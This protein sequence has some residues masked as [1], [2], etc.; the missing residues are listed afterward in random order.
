M[1][2]DIFTCYLALGFA[3]LKS[4]IIGIIFVLALKSKKKTRNLS[5]INVKLDSI[6]LIINLSL[7]I[8]SLILFMIIDYSTQALIILIL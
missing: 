1:E 7:T 5:T 6:I 8:L 3:L 2:C 4:L